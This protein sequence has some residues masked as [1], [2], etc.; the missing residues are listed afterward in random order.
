M[1]SNDCDNIFESPT[2][3]Y[4]RATI[5]IVSF[6]VD[7]NHRGGGATIVN[8]GFEFIEWCMSHQRRLKRTEVSEMKV[9]LSGTEIDIKP[10]RLLDYVEKVDFIKCG[11][12]LFTNW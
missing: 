12:E 1:W 7:F 8:Y 4:Y 2:D 11:G 3:P 9:S 10:K 6:A 5:R